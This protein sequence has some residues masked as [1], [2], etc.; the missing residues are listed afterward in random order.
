MS[1]TLIALCGEPTDAEGAK[2]SGYVYNGGNHQKWQLQSTGHGQNMTLR[3]VQANT[4]LWFQGQSF[5]P[6]FSVKSSHN[7]QEYVITAANRGFYISPAQQP[8]Y[9][10]SLLH[11]SG[12]NGAE[13]DSS[14]DWGR[15]YAAAIHS[16]HVVQSLPRPLS[17]KPSYVYTLDPSRGVHTRFNQLILGH[18][19]FGEY[20]R[21]FVPT[22]NVG[23]PCGNVSV[24]SASHILRDC[25]LHTEARVRL[26][27]ASLFLSLADLF[28]EKKGIKAL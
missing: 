7:S 14:C 12:Q 17:W 6:S 22:E 25:P 28:R 8:G 1:G 11:G 3:N 24:Q 2:I 4:H 26:R 23:C 10:L 5:V 13:S 27:K 16:P 19:F 21:R 9:A 20:Y 18:G 15:Q